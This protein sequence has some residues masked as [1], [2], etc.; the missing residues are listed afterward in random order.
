MIRVDKS[1]HYRSH[2]HIATVILFR[3]SLSKSEYAA[4]AIAV[5][6][7]VLHAFAPA[8]ALEYQRSLLTSQPWRIISGHLV[9]INWEHALINAVALWVVARLFAP[10]LTMQR[11]LA[12]LFITAVVISVGLALTYPAIEWYR[13]LSG[14]LHGL[15]FAGAIAWLLQARPRDWRHLW[16]PAVLFVGGWIKI[17]LEQPENVTMSRADWL[18]API[19]TQAHLIGAACGTIV[20]VLFAITNSRAEQQ[21]SQQQ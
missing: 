7:L 3:I 6:I 21:R 20:G 1:G 16:L 12:T 4:L 15:F 10:D 17:A 8:T 18:N 19:I 2:R 14:V 11:Q 9:H 13:G 5:V